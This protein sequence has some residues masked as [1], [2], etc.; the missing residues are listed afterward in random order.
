MTAAH[1]PVLA[2]ELIEALDPRPGEIV[3]DCTFGARRPRA[4]GRR[5]RSGRDGHADRDRPRP[6]R[7]GALR[8]ARRRGRRARRASSARLRRR[9][10]PQ[11]RAEGV[12]RRPRLHGPRHVLDAG[13]HAA[14]AASPTPTTRRSTCGWTPTR[15]SRARDVVNDVGRAPARAACSASYGEERYARQIA[16][17]IVRGAR[18]RRSRR[19]TSSSTSISGAIPAPARFAG[20]HPAKRIFQAIRIVVNDEL[21]QLDARAARSP[22]TS[23]ARTAALQGSRSTRWKTGA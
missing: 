9:R 23:C 19:R 1:V 16:R 20:G 2:G 8:R 17:A 7:R 13:R 3:V 6:A 11:L 22:G 12:A 15:S 18:R 10:S 21:G 4:P 5:P 14:S